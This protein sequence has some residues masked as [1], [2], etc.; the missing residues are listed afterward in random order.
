MQISRARADLYVLLFA[1]KGQSSG[2]IPTKT[3]RCAAKPV[4]RTLLSPETGKLPSQVQAERLSGHRGATRGVPPSLPLPQHVPLL[5]VWPVHA[6]PGSASHHLPHGDR[7][8]AISWGLLP[9]IWP[10]RWTVSTLSWEC[11]ACCTSKAWV[12]SHMASEL[13]D[14][15]HSSSNVSVSFPFYFLFI[16]ALNHWGTG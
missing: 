8:R 7:Q 4:P 2:R 5:P 3:P 10:G 14:L 16:F 9:K 12:H 6:N 11:W 13:N 1:L 15:L